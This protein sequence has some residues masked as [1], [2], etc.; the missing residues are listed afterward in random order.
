MLQN[1]QGRFSEWCKFRVRGMIP[2]WVP[3]PNLIWFAVRY[4]TFPQPQFPRFKMGV[5]ES[6]GANA[7]Y[8]NAAGW[9]GEQA[10]WPVQSVTEIGRSVLRRTSVLKA[11]PP[12]HP[13][14]RDTS[15]YK[16][17]L[18]S[19]IWFKH[20]KSVLTTFRCAV[21]DLWIYGSQCS[22]R[23]FW[24]SLRVYRSV[25]NTWW[26]NIGGL[27]I[28]CYEGSA[29]HTPLPPQLQM[30]LLNWRRP[31]LYFFICLLWLQSV[32]HRSWLGLRVWGW[33]SRLGVLSWE[34]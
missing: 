6:E 28:H 18:S 7:P 19:W 1:H 13:C 22:S 3:P 20:L 4:P 24:N 2:V 25:R 32:S 16:A 23:V 21:V 11:P 15:G 9:W 27:I 30:S 34:C 33:L 5:G 17:L 26:R 10:F 8:R 12:L 29:P 14:T 31:C